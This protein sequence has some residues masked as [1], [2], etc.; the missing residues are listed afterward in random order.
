[1]VRDEGAGVRAAGGQLQRRGLH[2]GEVA[3]LQEPPHGPPEAGL[4]VDHLLDLTVQQDVQVPLAEQDFLVGQARVLVRQRPQGL[5]ED[6]HLACPDRE[7]A[8]L[9]LQPVTLDRH[10]IAYVEQ[11]RE[12]LVARDV[13]LGQLPPGDHELHLAGLVVQLPEREVAHRAQ[14]H[15]P[16]G[17]GG[18]LT[19]GDL[20][21]AGDA[22]P[23]HRVGRVR[24][25][26]L[27]AE[28]VNLAD[29]LLP[30]LAQHVGP[31][32]RGARSARLGVRRAAGRAARAV[33]A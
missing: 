16:P 7:L 2:L 1:V 20:A 33:L 25:D 14:Q 30:D 27:L 3:V 31:A 5:G 19:V 22:D 21:G 32:G 13:I 15:D 29:P 8:R 12:G 23:V 9:G 26:A 18:G 17:D 10:E 24:V 28:L 6:R 4:G 11:L